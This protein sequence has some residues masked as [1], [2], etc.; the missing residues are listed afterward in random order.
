MAVY[1]R[2]AKVLDAE[3]K[4]VP[5]RG[6]LALINQTLDERLAEREGELEADSRWAL[7]WFDQHGFD[8]GEYGDAETLS[9]AMN[10]AIAGLAEGGVVA[11]GAGRV[12]LLRPKELAEDWDPTADSRVT[13]WEVVHQ[14]VRVLESGGEEDAATL[15][16]RLGGLAENRAGAGLSTLQHH[17]AQGAGCSGSFL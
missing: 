9:K 12:R 10:T 16:Q 3:G 8:E 15:L 14:L 17:G 7:A 4:P 5:V 2:Y 13:A 11:S 1:T 6:A